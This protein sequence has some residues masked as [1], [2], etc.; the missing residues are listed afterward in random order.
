M[1]NIDI[2]VPKFDPIKCALHGE[3]LAALNSKI[4]RVLLLLEG[5]G[6]PGIRMEIDRM[7][8]KEARR[9]RFSWVIIAAIVGTLTTTIWGLIKG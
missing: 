4:D 5:N 3:A 1:E 8:Q 6:Q 2:V 9:D 7:I